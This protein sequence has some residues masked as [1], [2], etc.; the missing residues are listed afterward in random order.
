MGE[1]NDLESSNRNNHFKVDVL[2]SRLVSSFSGHFSE[3]KK[4]STNSK[5]VVWVLVVWDSN[6]GTPKNPNPFHKGTLSESKPP[7]P[8]PPIYH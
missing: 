8:K 5:L 2:S 7:G 1:S 4:D 6:R 3:R